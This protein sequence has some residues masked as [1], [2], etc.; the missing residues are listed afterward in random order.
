M[1]NKKGYIR[2]LEAVIAIILIL[3]FIFSVLPKKQIEDLKTPR[4]ID[5]TSDRILNEVQNNEEFRGCVIVD[6]DTAPSGVIV[7]EDCIKNFIDSNNL[8]SQQ[9]M[10]Y[11]V[12]VCDPI[13]TLFTSKNYCNE[14]D[15]QEAKDKAIYTKSLLLSSTLLSPAIAPLNPKLVKLYIWRKV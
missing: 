12:L 3:I 8:I 15:L 5:L 9:T 6:E 2:T 14:P 1:V 4:E 13:A 11:K 10:G 7:G